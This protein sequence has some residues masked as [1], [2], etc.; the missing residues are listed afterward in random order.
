MTGETNVSRTNTTLVAL[1]ATMEG[2]TIPA[3]AGEAGE[4]AAL[5]EV[6]HRTTVG[7]ALKTSTKTTGYAMGHPRGG[8]SEW[9]GGGDY[10]GSG[11]RDGRS[12]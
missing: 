2:A 8:L 3:V 5:D 10:I 9:R 7:A 11:V 1:G 6:A 12:N 4:A